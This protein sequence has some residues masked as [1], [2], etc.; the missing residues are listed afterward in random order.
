MSYTSYLAKKIDG[1]DPFQKLEVYMHYYITMLALKHDFEVVDKRG[2]NYPKGYSAADKDYLG[3]GFYFLWKDEKILDFDDFVSE[4]N[5]V[6]RDYGPDWEK[7]GFAQRSWVETRGIYD[8]YWK[9][10]REFNF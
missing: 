7:N 5:L 2:K 3:I 6:V 4:S 1:F 9:H 8:W 10:E